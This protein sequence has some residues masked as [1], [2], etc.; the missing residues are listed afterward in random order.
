MPKKSKSSLESK[1][2][3]VRLFLCDV[4][5]VLTDATVWMD[6][7]TEIKRFC[8]SDGL[9]LRLLRESDIQIGWISHRP[10]PATE[11]R[12]RELSVDFLFQNHESKVATAEKI[13]SRAN[14]SWEN[15][16][17]MGDDIV[18]LGALK[19]AGLAVTVPGAIDEVKELA[20]II[21]TRPGGHGAVREV[22]NMILKAQKKW[23]DVINKYME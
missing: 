2:S 23:D 7:Q 3:K 20:H 21:T 22:I 9:G 1:L 15:T 4:D 12:A 16:C 19:R 8:V 13:L 5:G 18:D 10:S 14:V 6:R 17:Y 11:Q